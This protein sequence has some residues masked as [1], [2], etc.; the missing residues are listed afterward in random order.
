MVT[1]NTSVVND[2]SSQERGPSRPT[3]LTVHDVAR[4]LNCSARTVYR[5]CDSGRLPRPVKLGA[6]VR[7]P[8]EVVEQWIADGCPKAGKEV[9]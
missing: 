7:W 9:L 3:L 8:R 5:L 1:K 6:L 2:S 4:M